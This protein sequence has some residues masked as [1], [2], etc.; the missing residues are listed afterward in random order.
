MLTYVYIM[1]IIMEQT[2]MYFP[3]STIFRNYM[4][5][6]VFKILHSLQYQQTMYFRMFFYL[7]SDCNQLKL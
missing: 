6:Y 3:I 5:N 7:Q 4:T 2:M 1:L